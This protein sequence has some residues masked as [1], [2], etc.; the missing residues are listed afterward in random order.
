MCLCFDVMLPCC[1]KHVKN[2]KQNFGYRSNPIFHVL[3]QFFPCFL[4]RILAPIEL[5]KKCHEPNYIHFLAFCDLHRCLLSLQIMRF[6]DE[7]VDT[8]DR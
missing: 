5:Y 4:N 6:D 8:A 2:V 1:G 3:V 7:F